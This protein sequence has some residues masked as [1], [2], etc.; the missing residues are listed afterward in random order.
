MILIGGTDEF[1]IGSVHKIPDPFDLG[2]HVIDKLFR[3][4]AG[5]LGLQLDLLAVLVG[6]G[7]EKHIIALLSLETGDAVCE[8]DLVGVSDMRLA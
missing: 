2:R 8:N 6:S 1:I 5:F 7:L 3:S 4:D